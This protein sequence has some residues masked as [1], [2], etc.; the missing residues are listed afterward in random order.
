MA[1]A[2]DIAVV[3]YAYYPRHRQRL[4]A[5]VSR[6]LQGTNNSVVVWVHAPGGGFT[7]EQGPGGARWIEREHNGRGW[8]WGA[9]QAGLDTLRSLAWA[10]PVCFVNDTAGVHYPMPTSEVS[11]LRAAALDDAE[12][13]PV[14][15]GCVQPAPAGLALHG[16]RIAAWVRSN[17]F[18]LSPAALVALGHRLF[19]PEDFDSPRV[20]PRPAQGA[21]LHWPA[22]VSP[23]LAAHLN[24]WLLSRGKHGWRRH[25]GRTDVPPGQLRDKAGAILLEKRLAAV[26]AAA[27]GG[28]LVH[29]GPQAGGQWQ[30]LKL[31]AFFWQ[32][33]WVG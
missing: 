25:A 29:C 19:V 3:A 27:P 20:E 14:L 10:G 33:R 12:S 2:A 24:T 16:L 23:A 13:A 6:L 4:V 21:T 17:A 30:R 8:E 9:Y 28:R 5:L 7:V 22:A 31:R 11:A 26:V 18:V 1:Q 15:A 32:R